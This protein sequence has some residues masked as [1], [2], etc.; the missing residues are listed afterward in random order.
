MLVCAYVP[1]GLPVGIEPGEL[2]ID[3]AGRL[4]AAG[5]GYVGKAEREYHWTRGK[6]FMTTANC[7][8]EDDQPPARGAPDRHKKPPPDARVVGVRYVEGED[9]L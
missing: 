4:E 1:R 6:W 8:V 3:V 7:L 5:G 2:V 9:L